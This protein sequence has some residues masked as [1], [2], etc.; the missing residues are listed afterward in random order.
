MI[1][2]TT[3]HSKDKKPPKTVPRTRHVRAPRDQVWLCQFEVIWVS[4]L[5]LENG[6]E[7]AQNPASYLVRVPSTVNF[8]GLDASE[9]ESTLKYIGLDDWER[10]SKIK[11]IGLDAKET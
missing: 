3:H 7:R 10:E 11:C 8:V 6:R 5:A 9:C 2:S 1:L 4:R